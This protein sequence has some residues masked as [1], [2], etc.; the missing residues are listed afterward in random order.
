ML[1]FGLLA[2]EI[3]LPV[4][5]TPANFNGF[6]VL[7]ALLHGSQVVGVSQTL[8]RW[9]EGASYVRQGGRHVALAHILVL[10][11]I[12]PAPAAQR[13]FYRQKYYKI[14][15]DRLNET[16][17]SILDYVLDYSFW[18]AQ[19]LRRSFKLLF[20][21]CDTELSVTERFSVQPK[22]PTLYQCICRFSVAS[23]LDHVVVDI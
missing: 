3:G 10:I 13:T 16:N 1:N 9:T 4:W 21:F 17:S 14:G 18:P 12:Q 8:R 22:S 2:A 23:G 19:F 20:L 5:G 11:D 7:A 15:L 6:R